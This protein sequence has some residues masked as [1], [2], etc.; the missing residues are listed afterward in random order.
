MA[1]CSLVFFA[2]N[3]SAWYLFSDALMLFEILNPENTGIERLACPK[4]N[5]STFGEA[6]AVS[7]SAGSE[8]PNFEVTSAP[9]RR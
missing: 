2:L 6:G 4:I 3:T 5:W 8:P 7:P 1:N 9:V